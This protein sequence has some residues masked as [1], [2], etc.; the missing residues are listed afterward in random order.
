MFVRLK[1]CPSEVVIV[2]V[3]EAF[4]VGMRVMMAG[5]SAV[6]A[7]SAFL[8]RASTGLATSSCPARRTEIWHLIP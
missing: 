2:V 7:L 3:S 5:T 8:Q 6:A 1:Q 4:F